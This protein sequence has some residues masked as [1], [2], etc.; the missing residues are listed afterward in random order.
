MPGDRTV[1]GLFW[2]DWEIGME[3]ESRSRTVGEADITM[4][5]GL[6]GDYNPIHTDEVYAK[7]TI[8]GTRIA[9]G[10]LIY[11]IASGLL[12]QLHLYDDTLIAFLGFNRLTFT[13][14]VIAG[15]TIRARIKVVNARTTSHPERGIV[16]RELRVL[17]QRSECVQEGEQ[18]F[19]IKRR[20]ASLKMEQSGE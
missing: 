7:D 16:I 9:H 4:F 12:Y 1:L 18:V 17:N 15:D 6:S 5:A 20:E 19:L 2:E 10:S 3:W 8:F 11:A 14:P 13:R